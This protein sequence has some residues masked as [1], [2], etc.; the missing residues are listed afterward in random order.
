MR[1]LDRRDWWQWAGAILVTL[2][3]T[4]ALFSS[5]LPHVLRVQDA[6]FE[7]NLHQNVRLLVGIV[8]L[9]DINIIYSQLR[10]T[11]LRRELALEIDANNALERRG[12]ELKTLSVLD[13]LTGLYNRRLAEERLR[14]EV[15]RAHRHHHPLTVM[16]IDLDDFKQINDGFGH[17]AGDRV[18]RECAAHLKKATRV[19]DV[20]AR[21]GGDEFVVLL[22]DCSE[23]QAS[24]V[25]AHLGPFE[26][27][28]TENKIQV[29][30]S[31]GCSE[32]QAGDTPAGL[33]ERADKRLYDAKRSH[34]RAPRALAFTS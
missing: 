5:T 16:M 18:L 19:S 11:R 2:L 7:F 12:D 27:D 13:P 30:F 23:P 33:L 8:L 17:A 3:L 6:E 24:K 22:L 10:I 21:L 28:F 25:L 34:K 15:S 4:G 32:Y 9:F 26:V 20:A 31:I 29:A 14:E 1:R